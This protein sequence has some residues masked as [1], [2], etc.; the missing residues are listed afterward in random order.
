L[1]AATLDAVIQPIAAKENPRKAGLAGVLWR[2]PD[3]VQ[4]SYVAPQSRGTF[5]KF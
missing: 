5:P 1:D 4:R 3:A 2:V